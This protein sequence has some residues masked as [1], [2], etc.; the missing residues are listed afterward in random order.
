MDRYFKGRPPRK[1]E[2]DYFGPVPGAPAVWLV[3]VDLIRQKND[4]SDGNG[5]LDWYA[6]VIRLANATVQAN[7]MVG[8]AM[9]H[10]WHEA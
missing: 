9:P 7:G 1:L 8:L 10:A 4:P 6:N 2:A 5:W 3:S